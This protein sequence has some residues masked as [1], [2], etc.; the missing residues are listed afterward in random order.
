MNENVIEY[1]PN[2]LCFEDKSKVKLHGNWWDKEYKNIFI[3]I[4][5]CNRNKYPSQC[6]E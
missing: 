1:Y 3:A 5:S 4:E 6:A 2:S